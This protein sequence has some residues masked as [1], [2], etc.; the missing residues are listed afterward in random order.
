MTA[1]VSPLC[2]LMCSK[3]NLN[4]LSKCLFSTKLFCDSISKP[5]LNSTNKKKS[6]NS[7]LWKNLIHKRQFSTNLRL[8]GVLGPVKAAEGTFNTGGLLSKQ[9]AEELA[10][11]LTSEERN[12]LLTALQ[13]YQSKIVKDEYI[14]KQYYTILSFPRNIRIVLII[15][16]LF[17]YHP[18]LIMMKL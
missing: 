15:Y 10:L 12:L 18:F 9:Q 8:C 14:G 1:T 17:M 5:L 2:H 16:L 13:E 3:F 7:L 6:I 11:K 4:L